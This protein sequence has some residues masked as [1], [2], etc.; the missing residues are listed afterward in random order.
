LATP[1]LYFCG[2]PV[3]V[4]KMPKSLL[5]EVINLL[6]LPALLLIEY[7]FLLK[8]TGERRS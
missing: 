6:E 3:R 5:P 7:V 8:K 1:D 4:K 2:F